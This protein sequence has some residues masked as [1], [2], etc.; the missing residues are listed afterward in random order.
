MAGI[1]LVIQHRR[2]WLSWGYRTTI[3]TSHSAGRD[4]NTALLREMSGET[5]YLVLYE[6]IRG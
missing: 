4:K 6:Q 5:Y 1:R 3:P 2:D